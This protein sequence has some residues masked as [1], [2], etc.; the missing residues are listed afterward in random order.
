VYEH[1]KLACFKAIRMIERC[2][3]PDASA[4]ANARIG[5]ELLAEARRGC[6]DW[7]LEPTVVLVRLARLNRAAARKVPPLRR[8]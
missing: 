7:R 4:S 3:P 1:E 8:T 6:E 5:Q 2:Y